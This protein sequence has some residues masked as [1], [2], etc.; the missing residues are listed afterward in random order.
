MHGLVAGLAAVLWLGSSSVAAG[1]P[2]RGGWLK[3]VSGTFYLK[4]LFPVELPIKG[5]LSLFTVVAEPTP[6]WLSVSGLIAFTALVV[7]FACWR[8]RRAEVSYSSD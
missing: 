1:E 3:P 4:P 8:M 5:V 7:T 2:K 6:P